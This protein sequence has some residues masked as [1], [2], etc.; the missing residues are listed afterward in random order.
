MRNMN[1]GGWK[2]GRAGL[3]SHGF[4]LVSMGAEHRQIAVTMR[5][6]Q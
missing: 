2:P 3:S 4:G 5:S 6:P 1:A